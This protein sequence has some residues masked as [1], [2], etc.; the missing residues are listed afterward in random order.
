MLGLE[1]YQENIML[2]PAGGTCAPH[3]AAAPRAAPRIYFPALLAPADIRKEVRRFG[4][5]LRITRGVR[6]VFAGDS[7]G[8][9]LKAFSR[10]PGLGPLSL[11]H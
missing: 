6:V 5:Y 11:Q 9:F 3:P 4:L 2:S 10:F 8:T 7:L 1:T